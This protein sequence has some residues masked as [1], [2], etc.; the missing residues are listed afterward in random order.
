MLVT[1][2]LVTP[3]ACASASGE[4]SV[5]CLRQMVDGQ[6]ITQV[7]IGQGQG[8]LSFTKRGAGH[9]RTRAPFQALLCLVAVAGTAAGLAV[10]CAAA[11]TA[12]SA[13]PAGA[14]AAAEAAGLV[15]MVQ[16]PAGTAEDENRN[17]DRRQVK[18]SSQNSIIK[19]RSFPEAWYT[20]PRLL[21]SNSLLESN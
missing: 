4:T 2:G 21:G 3:M 12:A 1:L 15:F 20:H 6:Q 18:I 11:V 9:E 14:I 16:E 10:P 17:D 19:I 13:A 8:I 5:F 7:G